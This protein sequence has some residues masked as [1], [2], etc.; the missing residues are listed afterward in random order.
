[1]WDVYFEVFA[2]TVIIFPFVMYGK[3][4][5]SYFTM[6]YFQRKMHKHHILY[7]IAHPDDEAM[8]FVPSILHLGKTNNLHL[9]CMSTG[10]ADGLGRTREKELQASAKLL[11][12]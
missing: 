11:G 3:A 8:F 7:V 10:N 5:W 12:I 9:L 6:P 2:L 1:M 4:I